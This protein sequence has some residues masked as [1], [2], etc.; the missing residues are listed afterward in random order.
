MDL[1]IAKTVGVSIAYKTAPIHRH[2]RPVKT[3]N[4]TALRVCII[5]IGQ[6]LRHC[7]ILRPMT[8]RKC[9]LSSHKHFA[10]AGVG[11]QA[12]CRR[13]AMLAVSGILSRMSKLSIGESCCI[14]VSNVIEWTSLKGEAKNNFSLCHR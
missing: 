11:A 1:H 2:T 4:K 9:T 12:A 3:T 6:G 8:S 13:H 7:D 10:H 5:Y 14:I